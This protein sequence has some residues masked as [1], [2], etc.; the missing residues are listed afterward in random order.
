MK[1]GITTEQIKE[2]R[3][4][5]D[6]YGIK[7]INKANEGTIKEAIRDARKAD[8]VIFYFT[9][10]S[11]FQL[12]KNATNREAGR[13]AKGQMKTMPDIYYI[14]KSGFLKLIWEK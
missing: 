1:K 13:F 8:I 5:Y 11:Q 7:F 4:K 9:Q 3:A 10:E 14:D 12:L 2:A 6:S